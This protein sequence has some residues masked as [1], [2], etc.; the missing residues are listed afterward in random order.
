[1]YCVTN[2]P[3]TPGTKIR[4]NVQ[5]KP[6]AVSV[7]YNIKSSRGIISVCKKIVLAILIIGKNRVERILTTGGFAWPVERRGGD[8]VSHETVNK[9]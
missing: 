6:K 9:R 7:K 4:G 5:N 2:K 1:M 8:R 3:K